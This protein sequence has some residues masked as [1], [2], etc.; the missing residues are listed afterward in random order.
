MPHHFDDRTEHITSEA[1]KE[2]ENQ[3]KLRTVDLVRVAVD[4]AYLD[5][6]RALDFKF[7]TYAD[8]D[9]KDEESKALQDAR[10]SASHF[11]KRKTRDYEGVLPSI[12]D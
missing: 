4:F 3:C 6:Q 9:S 2:D 5:Q 12:L 8:G 7:S 1:I 11:I 10:K